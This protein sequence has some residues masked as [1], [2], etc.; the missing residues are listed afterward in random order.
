[1][2]GRSP[3]HETALGIR[4][5]SGWACAIL[6]TGHG[7]AIEILDRRRILLHD[8]KND[9]TKQPYHAAEPLR[10]ALAEN[11]IG[12]C[13]KTTAGLARDAI[14]GFQYLSRSRDARLAGICVITGS[15]RALPDLR[16]ILASHALIHAAEG[17]FYRNA[18]LDAAAALKIPASRLN[19]ARASASVAARLGI[20]EAV[21]AEMLG[22]IGKRIGRPWTVD[23]K[24]ATMAAWML[25][26]K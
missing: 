9:G 21:L 6:A 17:E 7:D 11:H 3:S 24:L 18:L 15:G 4:T 1:M 14:A 20:D 22:G 10:F 23:E 26:A 8:P 25:L 13:R 5:H 2:A 16:A 12:V 19:A